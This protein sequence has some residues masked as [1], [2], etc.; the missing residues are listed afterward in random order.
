MHRLG[1]TS[2]TSDED[3]VERTRLS[4]AEAGIEADDLAKALIVDCR[5]RIDRSSMIASRSLTEFQKTATAPPVADRDCRSVQKP[6]FQGIAGQHFIALFGD[7]YLL[8]E[9]DTVAFAHGAV[10]AFH[11]NDHPRF[12]NPVTDR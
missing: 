4:G 12:E 6:F 3:P 1:I 2:P 10:I 9:L 7:Q 11:A 8:F 5:S